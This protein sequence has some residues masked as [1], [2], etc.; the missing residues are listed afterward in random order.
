MTPKIYFFTLCLSL[1][2]LTSTIA[3][4]VGIGTASPQDKLHIN[5]G[6][7]RIDTLSSL[8]SNVVLSDVNGRLIN[9][10]SG[11]TGQV[12][13]SQG[14]GRAPE[15][16][17]IAGSNSGKI[18]FGSLSS[19]FSLTVNSSSA[20]S[21]TLLSYN[22]TPANDT[23]ILNFSAEGNV[24]SSSVPTNPAQVY[25]FR[26]YVNGALHKQTYAET[27]RN[28]SSGGFVPVNFNMPIAV[29]AGAS[30]NVRVDVFTLFTF[31]G[32]MT[33]SYDPTSLSQYANFTIYDM[34]TN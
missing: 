12:L 15:W 9:L 6:Y 29:N 18:H 3:Q 2:N 8:D 25:L 22:F 30:N 7:L 5:G 1:I 19:F 31:S 17:T 24:S 10:E 13:T 34:P 16:T 14:P 11:T 21:G 32:S 4:N 28:S 33:L 23:V 27:T 26:L 20:P